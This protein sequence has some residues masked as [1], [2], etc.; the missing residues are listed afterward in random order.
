[1]VNPTALKLFISVV[2]KSGFFIIDRRAILNAI[3]WKH[4][5]AAIDDLIHVAGS[6][7][8]ADVHR[9]SAHV[10][11]LRD[12]PE[13][14]LVLSGLSR[15]WKIC[16]CDPVFQD[17]DGNGTK[18]E[19]HLHVRPTLQR[20]RFY[21][22]PPATA[23]PIILGPTS[24]ELAIGTSTSKIVAK[25]EASQKQKAS[26]F[27]VASSNVAK[28]TSD[29]DDD[30]YVEIPLVT[31]LCSAV[32]IPSLGNRGGSFVAPA[33]EGSNTR[34]SR[35][36]G[37]MVDD[38]AA[39]FA[40]VSQLRP[41]FRHA[42]S[43][44][45]VSGDV[46]HTD[47]FLFSDGPYYATYH[48]DGVAGNYEFIREEWDAL[49]RPTFRILIKEMSVL[50]GMMLLHGGELFARYHRLTQSHHEYVLSTNSR[51]KGY[52]EKVD[53]STGLELYVSTL[54]KQVS[55]HNDKLATSNAS[56]AK[57]K[58]K[59]KRGRKRLSRLLK[60]W[61]I[62]ILRWLVDVGRKYKR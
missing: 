25:A 15:G 2:E 52:K 13:G 28:R 51:V 1:M 57:S 61:I 26:N 4:P 38:T 22:T 23:D 44:W 33:A 56:F 10:V 60:V 3:V 62:C 54:K 20:L 40:G 21:F 48:E 24:G 49:Y 8:M 58:A 36:K 30:A 41:S 55:G 11:K 43:F 47:F 59:G 9:L 45:Y 17:V 19:P 29:N 32:V 6:F 12:M 53:S 14:V 34:D 31:P 46:I 5:D 27:G 37:V 50:Y 42:S 39:P 18:E 7:N 35:G 16:I